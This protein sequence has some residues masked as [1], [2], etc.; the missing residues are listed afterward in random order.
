MIAPLAYI[1]IKQAGVARTRQ[2]M[3]NATTPE[4]PFGGSSKLGVT[5][6]GGVAAG[7]SGS[8][9]IGTPYSSL[10]KAASTKR[11]GSRDCN[12]LGQLVRRMATSASEAWVLGCQELDIGL[13]DVFNKSSHITQRSVVLD[14]SLCSSTG[15]NSHPRALHVHGASDAP[16]KPSQKCRNITL[17]PNSM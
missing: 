4:F 5:P 8:K 13:S 3:V 7:D 16:C 17:T 6:S 2:M 1:L 9:Y 12:G 11:P 10:C 15:C 14:P